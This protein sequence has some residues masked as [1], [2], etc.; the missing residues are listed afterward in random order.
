MTAFFLHGISQS[1][2]W[3][4]AHS[5]TSSSTQKESDLEILLLTPHLK[6]EHVSNAKK[7]PWLPG[8]F[9]YMIRGL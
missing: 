6:G 5:F 3:V 7:V 1:L 2:S 4:V 9:G 8:C